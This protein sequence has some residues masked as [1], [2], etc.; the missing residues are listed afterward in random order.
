MRGKWRVITYM[1]PGFVIEMAIGHNDGAEMMARE[2]ARQI[3]ERGPFVDDGRGI[4]TY[5]PPSAVDKVKVLP[6][7]VELNQTDTSVA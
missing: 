4:R 2:H 1:K 6:P 7:D 5:Y 3:I